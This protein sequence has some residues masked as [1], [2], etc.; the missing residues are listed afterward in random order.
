MDN[1]VLYGFETDIY[2]NDSNKENLEW[3]QEGYLDCKNVT[4][5][6]VGS[7][8]YSVK[9]LGIKDANQDV[10]DV[11]RTEDDL[12]SELNIN[13]LKGKSITDRHPSQMVSADN[14][15]EH[16]MGVVYDAFRYDNK[17][18]G[19]M[20]I[21]DKS[22][23]KKVYDGKVRALSLG[24]IAKVIKDVETNIYKFT[25]SIN[26]HVALVTKGRDSEAFIM[27]SADIIDNLVGEGGERM[28]QQENITQTKEVN[29]AVIGSLSETHTIKECSYDTETDEE[30]EKVIETRI[31]RR[32]VDKDKTLTLNDTDDQP[33]KEVKDEK[34]KTNK[35]EKE[36]ENQPNM[37]SLR[38][39]MNEYKEVQDTFPKSLAKDAELKR[40][41]DECLELHKVELTPVEIKDEKPNPLKGLKPVKV[42]DEK[43]VVDKKT[44]GLEISDEERELY[45]KDFYE[46]LNPFSN[47][48]DS[49]KEGVRH[50]EKVSKADVHTL[51]R[52]VRKVV[53]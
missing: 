11:Y 26:N 49:Y 42:E 22:M 45:Q 28:E 1:K 50:L 35:T 16:E 19:K 27:D 47:V 38:E 53:L 39:F 30:I 10:V 20:L 36:K 9:E 24:Y 40:I 31:Y 48:H 15:K 32:K 6:H 37:K 46:G 3:T 13:S 25:N 43:P 33:N 7:R 41:N 18:N 44:N 8:K 23:A 21:K 12:F 29:D 4:F 2:I 5:A 52:A 34:E 14:W 51:N 17:L